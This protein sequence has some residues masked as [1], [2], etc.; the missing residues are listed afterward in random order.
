MDKVLIDESIPEESPRKFKL[1]EKVVIHGRLR[2]GVRYE[3]RGRCL[4]TR[5]KEWTWREIPP[6]VGVVVGERTLRDGVSEWQG[7]DGGGTVFYPERAFRA[8]LV[9]TDI[10]RNPFYVLPED[11]E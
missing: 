10:R 4:K 7:S 3:D 5:L 2:R 9:V 8:L 11:V 6:E 1:G